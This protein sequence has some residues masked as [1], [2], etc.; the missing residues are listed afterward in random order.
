MSTEL[1]AF[2]HQTQLQIGSRKFTTQV[3]LG[4]DEDQLHVTA[5]N[6]AFG[7][8]EVSKNS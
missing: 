4:N 7:R 2:S 8:V 5:D 1:L 3:Q 6:G